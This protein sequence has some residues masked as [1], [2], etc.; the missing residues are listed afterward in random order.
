ME[1]NQT[2]ESIS[3]PIFTADLFRTKASPLKVSTLSKQISKNS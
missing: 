1:T 3:N 2:E